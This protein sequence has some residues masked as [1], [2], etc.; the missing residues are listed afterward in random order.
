MS[1]NSAIGI[2]MA[3]MSE[4]EPF[5]NGLSLEAY[6]TDPFLIYKKDRIHLILSG[7]GKVSAAMAC[8][9]LITKFEPSSV[10]N[11]G[12]AGAADTRCELGESFHITEV[13]EPDR[14]AF[15]SGAWH[16]CAPD[17]FKGFPTAVL[18]S[19]D[20]AV[21]D[22]LER[23]DLSLYAQLADMEGAAVVQTC[24]R[25]HTRCYLFKF[26]SD[27]SDENGTLDIGKNIEQYRDGFYKFFRSTVLP[28]V[29]RF[30]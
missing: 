12:A 1:E 7:I 11:L 13:L 15:D 21:T 22:D 29:W 28:R 5:I 9:Y 24:T 16:K 2:V 18:A 20:R 8:A 14:P 4:V 17:T 25:F 26:V 19:Q 3:A 30:L 23:R 27:V 10:L 6:E